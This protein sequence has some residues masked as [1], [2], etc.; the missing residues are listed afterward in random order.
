MK[1]SRLLV[2]SALWLI[3]LGANAADLVERVAPDQPATVLY[4][5]TALS[6][7]TLT[8]SAYAED[9]GFFLYNVGAAKYFCAGNDYETRASLSTSAP[10]VYFTVTSAAKAKGE[11]V[12][13]LKNYVPKFSEFRSAFAGGASDFWTDNNTR[14]DRFWKV[15]VVEDNK[16][17]ISN[18]D[19][20][21]D[22][23]VGWNGSEDDTRLYLLAAGGS[24]SIDWQ[25]YEVD[26]WT[27]YF[28][29]SKVF[30]KS[31]ELKAAIESAEGDGIDVSAAVAV[32]NNTNSTI[33][34]MDAAIKALREAQAN[35]ISAGT[36]AQPTT[37]TIFITNP[38][39]ADNSRD[40][41]TIKY[42]DG[43]E[44]YDVRENI[45][46]C[47]GINFYYFQDL[48]DILNGVY[49]LKAQ[50]F[51]R[52]GS[53]ED[54]YK[55]WQA[56]TNKNLKM[57]AKMGEDSV[58][59]AVSN[60]FEGAVE[61]ALGVGAEVSAGTPPLY[62]PND[63]TAAAG[64]FN[65]EFEVD[66]VKVIG[67]YPN[68][69]F[70]GTDDN[71]ARI[72]MAKNVN[73]G[74]NWSIW[75]KWELKYYGNSP[76]A[77]AYWVKNA[78]KAIEIPE[79]TVYSQ[80]YLDAYNNA[81]GATAANK[82]EALAAIAAIDAAA[83]D[84]ELNIALWKE[85]SDVLEKAK[86]VIS[87]TSLD[88]KYRDDVDDW[89]YDA[90][91]MIKPAQR[92]KYTNEQIRETIDEG[93]KLIE[94]A[95]KHP[96]GER[97]M[98]E[99]LVNPDFEQG[100]KGWTGFKS[101]LQV[102][103]GGSKTMP[104]TGGT[105][106]N[107]CAEA[108]STEE[109]DLYQV[110]ENA[111]VGVYE[112][113]VQ[114]FC[115]NGRGDT[116]WSNYENQTFYS[117]PGKF[118][119]WVY[120]NA[121]TTPFGSVFAEPVEEGYY[122]SVDAGAEV[123]VHDGQEYPDGM[124][125]SAVAFAD[126]M[127]KQK[128]YG[129]VAQEGDPI[130]IGVKG[131]SAGLDGEDDNW[132]IFDNFK[133]TWKGFDATVI[134]PVLEARIA[135]DKELLKE[136]MGKAAYN[137][138]LNAINAAEASLTGEDGETMFN[139]LNA[140]FEVGAEVNTS[141][142]LFASLQKELNLLMDEMDVAENATA[143]AEANDLYSDISKRLKNH[144]IEDSE[145]EDLID[146]IRAAI[147]KMKITGAEDASDLNPVDMTYLLSNPSY[148]ENA[149]DWNGTKPG[150]GGQDTPSA[151]L[152]NT[153]YDMYQTFYG[154]PAGTYQVSLNGYYR[155]GFA[156]DDY[157]RKDSVEYNLAFLYAKTQDAEGN[158]VLSSKA[159][160]RLNELLTMDGYEYAQTD[161]KDVT[162]FAVA[163]T[164][165]IAGDPETYKYDLLPNMI[166]TAYPYLS[167]DFFKNVV[168]VKVAEGAPLR[169]GLMKV[170][171]VANDWTYFDE[172]TLIYFGPESAKTPDGDE[173]GI[174]DMNLTN[175]FKSEYFTL[176]GRKATAAQK[177]III[178]KMTFSNGAVVVRK[179]RR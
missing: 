129:L 34:Q 89:E 7:M 92:N 46:E 148:S 163:H 91:D 166:S 174:Q 56:G 107:T 70:F 4:D 115:R 83:A 73:I 159:L 106:T 67:H 59:V 125:S 150:W 35:N 78:G 146:Q 88:K 2:L 33:E 109:F 104:T 32:Y 142:A 164:D 57:Y 147:T 135:S 53:T 49:E 65:D 177:G 81:C 141:I 22:K 21:K 139:C 176:D 99:L 144:E 9:H 45:A 6:E 60:I 17:R 158:D 82:A 97:D 117:Q 86:A 14:A 113:E 12:V 93:L 102:K 123:Y 110:V 52:A 155:A 172:W 133:L 41:W 114:G 136:N 84:L 63:M 105:S 30:Q 40:G 151:E 127:Y 124:K 48:K 42:P 47:F 77:F 178:Q 94:E 39:Y 152:F 112:I 64:Y 118:P 61:D 108:F 87:D 162:D 131:H 128:A 72:G 171:K 154:L 43:G 75:G 44:N 121:N 161:S 140:L 13:E 36:V 19:N 26:E 95:Q 101:A 137:N 37:A 51:Y 80:P 169:I 122:K 149:D 168:T 85:L 23:F 71:T 74:N 116:A 175:E 8:P 130:R 145:V 5:E 29:A 111:P 38:D 126:G 100:E 179:I 165:T 24:A 134:K 62:V 68:S 167:N 20:E 55:N 69:L 173:S 138:L 27:E 79:G 10:V 16:I 170:E 15:T 132:V 143:A 157:A 58:T 25:L 11:G 96:T 54:S 120:L 156:S 153:D 98:T 160:H 103:W 18:V 90:S 1:I 50:A 76:E 3:G 66:E 119:V 28:Q 31:E